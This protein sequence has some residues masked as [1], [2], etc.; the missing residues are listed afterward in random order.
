MDPC[1]STTSVGNKAR[2][3]V[4]TM[5]IKVF[6][7]EED[8]TALVLQL[9]PSWKVSE[10]TVKVGYVPI[11]KISVLVRKYLLKMLYCLL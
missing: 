3:K 7:N 6:S 5:D 10:V 2:S 11:R 9:R 1:S 4:M 8:V